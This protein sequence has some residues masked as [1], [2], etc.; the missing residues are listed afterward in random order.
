MPPAVAKRLH[1]ELSAVLAMPEVRDI[2]ARE[3]AAPRPGTPDDLRQLI[4]SEYNRWTR[5]IKEADIQTE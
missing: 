4:S 3:G 2:L 1:E 5:L